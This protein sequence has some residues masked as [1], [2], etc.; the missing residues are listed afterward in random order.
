MP[1]G[2]VGVPMRVAVVG[3]GISGL[4]AAWL[5][6][7]AHEVEL[8]EADDRVG[9]HTNTV[10]VSRPGGGLVGADTGFIVHN[11]VT[12]PLLVRLFRELGVATQDAQMGFSVSC[13]RCRLEFS[14]VGLH[15]Q[16][17]LLA[18]A[19]FR[20]LVRDLVRFQRRAVRAL[21]PEA[22]GLTLGGFA[23]EE[24]YSPEFVR[25]YLLPLAAAVWSAGT[26]DA[27][28]FPAAYVV[29]FWHNHG[30]LGFRRLQWR[31][32]TGGAVSYVKAMVAPMAGRVHAGRPVVAVRRDPAGVDLRTADGGVHRFDAVVMATHP[33]QALAALADPDPAERRVLGAFR[34]TP[35][36]AVLHTDARMLPAR[37]RARAAWNYHL[38]DC[39]A[40]GARPAVT[41]SLNR[42]QRLDVGEE[43][44]VTLNRG[45][46]IDPDRVLRRI[47][48]RH[49]LYDF[50]T[51]DAQAA[52]P[53]LQG[54]RR[55]W[56]CGAWLGHGFH[57]D[58]LRSA[59][60]V[61][62]DLGVAW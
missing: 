45:E 28:R 6:G 12:Y 50:A 46:E 26:E 21:R 57:E 1:V 42:L 48:Y 39:R 30:I 40:P 36:E 8:F 11:E 32:V 54:A 17:D 16:A 49:P 5:L 51:L 25:H 15:R 33:D 14:G 61:A 19:G 41:Y 56:F 23:R 53:R 58:G 38:A 4:G 24:R 37:P 27:L 43:L 59:V 29:G 2:T 47:A 52:M 18:R 55:T 35:S 20:R 62:R 9:G 13:A 60:A 31:T 34:Y 44:C 10:A 7:R 3:S 22:A